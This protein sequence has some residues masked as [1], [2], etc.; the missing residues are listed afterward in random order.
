MIRPAHPGRHR[1]APPVGLPQPRLSAVY[2]CFKRIVLPWVPPV[3]P[4]D[5]DDGC[6]MHDAVRRGDNDA[7]PGDDGDAGPEDDGDARP[8]SDDEV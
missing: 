6:P 4:E 8:L 1:S 3:R 2:A 5:D 7:V